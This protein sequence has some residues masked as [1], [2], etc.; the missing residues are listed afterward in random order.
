MSFGA[1]A[2]CPYFSIHTMQSMKAKKYV[3]YTSVLDIY[4]NNKILCLPRDQC[5]RMSPC[6]KELLSHLKDKEKIY[7]FSKEKN[8]NVITNL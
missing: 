1:L 6:C 3:T 4:L 8:S 7:L 5:Y 2:L